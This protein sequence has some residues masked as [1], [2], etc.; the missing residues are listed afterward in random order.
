MGPRSL[1]GTGSRCPCWGRRCTCCCRGRGPGSGSRSSRSTV[2]GCG[3]R[4]AIHD[5]GAVHG[6]GARVLGIRALVRHHDA[7]PADRGVHH[8][9]ERVEVA[10]VALDPPVVD[11]VRADRV[12]D[13]EQRRDLV[14]LEDHLAAVGSRMNPTLKNRSG[15]SG[16]RALAWAM[17]KTPYSRQISPS[18][19]VSGP[20]TSIAHVSREG[21]VVE[22]EHLVVERLQRALRQRDQSDRQI[23]RG[24]PARRLHQVTV[25]LDV[26]HDVGSLRDPR[27]VGMSPTALY[28]SIMCIPPSLS[29]RT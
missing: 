1:R 20:G 7:E 15:H 4:R 10:A 6:Q 2:A 28:G 27:T 17:M 9:P 16:W 18:A 19:S 5:L 11:V 12:L 3:I 23:E 13:R 25:M 22:V 21:G 8:R 24:Q 29:D 14:V 26:A